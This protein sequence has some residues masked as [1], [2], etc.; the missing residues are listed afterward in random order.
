MGGRKGVMA[1]IAFSS[2]VLSGTGTETVVGVVLERQG[3]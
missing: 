3:R 1:F 2:P